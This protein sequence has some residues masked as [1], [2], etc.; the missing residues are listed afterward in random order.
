MSDVPDQLPH[1]ASPPAPRRE[2]TKRVRTGLIEI[3][4]G[5][6]MLGGAILIVVVWNQGDGSTRQGLLTLAVLAVS[7]VVIL[8]GV[9]DLIRGL[10]SMAFAKRG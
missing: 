1:A 5:A 9:I 10:A 6:L 3:G 4:V 8:K 2:A 7:V